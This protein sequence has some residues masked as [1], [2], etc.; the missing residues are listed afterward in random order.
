MNA[1][2]PNKFAVP[3]LAFGSLGVV[4]GDIGTSPI[5]T[6]KQAIQDNPDHPHILAAVSLVIWYLL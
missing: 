6:L 4:F 1:S 3:W 5:Y 2:T